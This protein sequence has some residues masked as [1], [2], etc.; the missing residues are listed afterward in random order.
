[1]HKGFLFTEKGSDIEAFYKGQKDETSMWNTIV[2][3]P[4]SFANKKKKSS[5]LPTL[6]TFQKQSNSY[7]TSLTLLNVNTFNN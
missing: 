5:P 1:M 3:P 2:H 6:Q 4:K 7:Q